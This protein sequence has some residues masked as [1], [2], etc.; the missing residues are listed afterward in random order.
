[1]DSY[2][3]GTVCSVKY[4]WCDVKNKTSPIPVRVDITLVDIVC[5]DDY[6]STPSRAEVSSPPGRAILSSQGLHCLAEC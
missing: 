2:G 6:K 5:F 4:T 1:M 3:Q